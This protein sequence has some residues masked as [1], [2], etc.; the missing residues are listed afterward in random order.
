MY[1]F[2]IIF[3]VYSIP[4]IF[5]LLLFSVLPSLCYSIPFQPRNAGVATTS[6]RQSGLPI[7]SLSL[8]GLSTLSLPF[9]ST[10]L[11]ACNTVPV[12]GWKVNIREMEQ[13][14]V[15]TLNAQVTPHSGTDQSDFDGV[16]S[17]VNPSSH[18]RPRLTPNTF[19]LLFHSSRLEK[20]VDGISQTN[21]NIGLLR[22][23]FQT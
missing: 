23:C 8:G 18:S 1:V 20:T 11:L 17:R 10:S 15:H 7:F 12:G 5:S 4:L 9:L 13:I 21:I 16:W 3:L 6:N 14:Y 19:I 2:F 22:F